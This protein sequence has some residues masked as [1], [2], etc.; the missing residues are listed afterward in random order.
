MRHDRIERRL[1]AIEQSQKEPA[2][3]ILSWS[4]PENTLAYMLSNGMKTEEPGVFELHWGG[5]HMQTD[6][7]KI[8]WI[9]NYPADGIDRC[10][11]RWA[12]SDYRRDRIALI[13]LERLQP[14]TV[15]GN[16]P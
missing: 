4:T 9:R 7:Q 11:K 14:E 16:C 1:N 13:E 6:A 2:E 8:R 5:D 10:R 15:L 12:S 3:Y